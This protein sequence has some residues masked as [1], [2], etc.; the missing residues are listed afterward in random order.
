VFR[1]ANNINLDTKGRFA[2]PTKLRD[3]LREI[4]DAQLV[5]TIDPDRCLMVY[6]LPVWLELEEKL[7]GLSQFNK[8]VRKFQRLLVGY[9]SEIEMD[10]QGRVLL[11]APLREFAG[12]TKQ[13]VLIGQ[14]T[15]L[16]LWDKA[17]WLQKTGESVDEIDQDDFELPSELE[18]LSF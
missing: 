10:A 5:I 16:E 17:V 13:M 3:P 8:A 1:G 7:M 2:M 12:L 11:S 18:Q 4:C 6:P 9:A 15:K 14:G